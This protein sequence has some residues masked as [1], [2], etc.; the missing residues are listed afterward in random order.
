MTVTEF[1]L[2]RL[3]RDGHGDN[4]LLEALLQC[5]EIQDQ[6]VDANQPDLRESE[7]NLSNIYLQQ[8]GDEPYL[9]ITAPWDS[10][11]GHHQWMQSP[12]NQDAM[13]R[14]LS[15]YIADDESRQLFHME[16]A[17][18]NCRLLLDDV[19]PR[20]PFNVSSLSID[21]A[22]KAVAQKDYQRLE[23]SLGSKHS[24]RHIWAG[25]RIEDNERGESLVVFWDPAVR[26]DE[27]ESFLKRYEQKDTRS[28]KCI[29]NECVCRL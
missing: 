20:T 17:G 3:R 16:P 21:P 27:I 26:S 5:I 1:A 15:P 22:N 29:G 7:K 24:R 13:S 28:F 19:V 12:E 14:L 11:A 8:D 2:L 10:P 9:L 4:D 23:E 6:W 18:T 25:W